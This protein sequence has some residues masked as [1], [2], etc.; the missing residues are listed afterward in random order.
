MKAPPGHPQRFWSNFANLSS[1][2]ANGG[3]APRERSPAQSGLTGPPLGEPTRF[4]RYH[5]TFMRILHYISY[6][7]HDVGG[8]VR[9]TLDLSATLAAAGHEVAIA[10]YDDEA[11]PKEWPKASPSDWTHH[12]PAQPGVPGVPR[13][14]KLDRPGW[15]ISLFSPQQLGMIRRGMTGFQAVHLHGVW[16]R[17]NPQVASV[18]RELRIPYVVSLRGMLDD[19]SMSQRGLKKRLFL[20]L[21][22]RRTLERAAFVHCTAEGEHEQARKWFPKGRGTVIPNLIDLKPYHHL[23]GPDAARAAFP[24]LTNGRPSVLFLSRVHYKKGVEVL[25]DAAAMLR[26][27]G[28]DVNVL[29]AGGG[30][31]GYI[32]GLRQQVA[33]LNL[34]D[35]VEFLGMVKSPLKES[36]Y[37]AC[38]VFALPTSQ[39]NFG[40]VFYEALACG[41]PVVTTFDVDTWPELKASGGAVIVKRNAGAFVDAI[42]A[43]LADN[44][45]REDMGRSGRAWVLENLET[46]K[47]LRLFERTYQRAI[48][49][50]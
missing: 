43:V 2:G 20:S 34:A 39:E 29:I 18:A 24:L 10:T 28:V 25:L 48:E 27:A 12:A 41:L 49:G 31:D 19:W 13:L 37:Q 1:V 50:E 8:P 30:E 35:R 40:F 42:K 33:R 32:S 45:A 6:L 47:V 22:G 44:T 23:P 46:S 16:E 4:V 7:R 38:R 15:P 9:A 14:W 36:L 26:D 5:S 3:F 21:A 11:W 17:S